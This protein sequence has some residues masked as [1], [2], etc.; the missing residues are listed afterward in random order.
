MFPAVN[1]GALER[2]RVPAADWRGRF[3]DIDPAD[4]EGLPFP[5]PE[6]EAARAS[7]ITEI[8]RMQEILYAQS[9][10]ALLIV[11]Q[12][13]D[14]S[15]KDG[16][17]RKVFS[18]I[19]PLGAVAVAFKKPT[20]PELAHDFLWR[21]HKAVPAA[22]MIH[23]QPVALRRRARRQGP[24]PS[25]A[26]TDRGTLRPDQSLRAAPR[27]KRC[28]HPQILPPHLTQRTK[29]A[30]SGSVERSHQAMEI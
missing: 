7:D 12:G 20:P 17:I 2:Y 26:G 4:R 9:K 18:P 16:T 13:L 19:N 25:A 24:R 14:T 10:R 11:L 23:L 8:D 21:I 30:A 22:G 29:G 5:R 3:T 1:F 6:A 15:G 27:R 28:N